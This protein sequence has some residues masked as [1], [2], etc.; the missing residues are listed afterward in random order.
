MGRRS[1]TCWSGRRTTPVIG[2]TTRDLSGDG[3]VA[4]AVSDARQRLDGIPGDPARLE[5]VAEPAHVRPQELHLL[6]VAWAP[7][8]AQEHLMGER[9]AGGNGELLQKVELRRRQAQL[10]A[11]DRDDASRQV[12]REPAHVDDAIPRGCA[13]RASQEGANTGQELADAERLGQVVVGSRVERPDLVGLVLHRG[14]EEDGRREPVAQLG[15]H[16][17]AVAVGQHQ[18]EDHEV[19]RRERRRGQRL[20]GAGRRG[21]PVA[22]LRERDLERPPDRALVVD[23]EDQRLAAHGPLAPAAGSSRTKVLPPPGVSAERRTSPPLATASPRAIARPS[24][25]PGTSRV[26]PPREKGSKICLASSDATP[27]P[28]SRTAISTSPSRGATRT[29][30]SRS[31]GENLSAFS[32]TFT[33]TRWSWGPSP[34]TRGTS[35]AASTRTRVCDSP[36]KSS[37]TAASTRS[38][39]SSQSAA[40]GSA[41]AFRRERSRRFST[42]LVIL[43][44]SA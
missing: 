4:K 13:V 17:G 6:R 27:G 16:L 15:A 1:S 21:Y 30:T 9:P 42:I 5:L 10:D 44:L 3:G 38:R 24:P 34:R 33:T 43:L 7:D 20:G 41:P 29:S 32:T 8:L 28:W 12:D 35:A 14:D 26:R 23:D 18:I 36:R 39:G 11:D 37:A 31:V 40:G 25:D 22:R 2:S 19:G